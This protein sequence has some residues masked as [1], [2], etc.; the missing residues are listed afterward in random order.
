MSSKG[1]YSIEGLVFRGK[2]SCLPNPTNWA[3]LSKINASLVALFC[4]SVK[5]YFFFMASISVP[6]VFEFP[7][8]RVSRYTFSA[9]F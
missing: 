2:I 1:S 5:I 4:R 6:Q 7:F 8:G 3:L 9:S